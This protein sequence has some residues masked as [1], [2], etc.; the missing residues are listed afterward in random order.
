MASVTVVF[1]EEWQSAQT[2]VGVDRQ[3]VGAGVAADVL[4]AH[5]GLDGGVERRVVAARVAASQFV[6]PLAIVT[7][8]TSC[9]SGL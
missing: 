2:S 8:W 9:R 4:A 5:G 7:R 3:Q 1:D 6:K